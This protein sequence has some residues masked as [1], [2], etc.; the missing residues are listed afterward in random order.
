MSKKYAIVELAYMHFAV[1]IEHLGA[2][3]SFIRVDR[4][5]EGGRYVYRPEKDQRLEV[6]L[7]EDFDH[8]SAPDPI[9]PAD[10]P[11]QPA[12][13]D[14]PAETLALPTDKAPKMTPPDLRD[15][16]DMYRDEGQ[17]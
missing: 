7:I 5:Y 12:P 14:L 1:P 16:V 13:P 11:I 2:I 8:P 6:V 9:A 15:F 3:P 10:D 4:G 17:G